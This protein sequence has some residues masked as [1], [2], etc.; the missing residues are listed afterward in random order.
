M[1]VAN[2]FLHKTGYDRFVYFY[3]KIPKENPLLNKE[4]SSQSAEKEFLVLINSKLLIQ[5]NCYLL[6]DL[7]V[8]LQQ[9]MEMYIVLMKT[10]GRT[11]R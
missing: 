10:S 3:R 8:E 2:V 11:K 7:V 6:S 1:W 9:L 4:V 5:K